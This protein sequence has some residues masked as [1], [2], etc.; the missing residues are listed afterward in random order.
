MN[1]PLPSECVFKR[2]QSSLA[3]RILDA[4]PAGSYALSGLLRLLDVV[5]TEEVQTAAVECVAQPRLLINPRFVAHTWPVN[6]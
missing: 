4:F 6:Q 3:A 2:N 5:E 1:A